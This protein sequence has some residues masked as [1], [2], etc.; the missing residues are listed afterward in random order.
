MKCSHLV[1]A[2]TS[3]YESTR[4]LDRILAESQHSLHRDATPTDQLRPPTAFIGSPHKQTAPVKIATFT[5]AELQKIRS[6]VCDNASYRSFLDQSRIHRSTILSRSLDSLLSNHNDSDSTLQDSDDKYSSDGGRCPPSWI[7][8]VE[9]EEEV[10]GVDG[11]IVSGHMLQRKAAPRDKTSQT[12]FNIAVSTPK[13]AQPLQH[14]YSPGRNQMTS[15]NASSLGNLQVALPSGSLDDIT[16]SSPGMR[17]RHACLQS[18]DSPDMIN[19]RAATF[20]SRMDYTIDNGS[21]RDTYFDSKS[22]SWS[23]VADSTRPKTP[24]LRDKQADFSQSV[25]DIQVSPERRS[26]RHKRGGSPGKTVCFDFTPQE[27]RRKLPPVYDLMAPWLK[28]SQREAYLR[29]LD[30]D[31]EESP[32]S[33]AGDSVCSSSNDR[34]L[35]TSLGVCGNNAVEGVLQY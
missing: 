25:D 22:L 1:A 13:Q 5:H 17:L 4:D 2:G 19:M 21:L 3:L 7:Q 30:H 10:Q 12:G 33:F 26:L 35:G 14:T 16:S 20:D 11:T 28:D 15:R 23:R 27:Q 32:S 8:E 34:S 31:I 18:T 6:R 29:R 24:S 9:S